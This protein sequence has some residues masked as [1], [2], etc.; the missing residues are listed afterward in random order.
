LFLSILPVWVDYR[1]DCQYG[2]YGDASN[3]SDGCG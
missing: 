2:V 1:S 3:T